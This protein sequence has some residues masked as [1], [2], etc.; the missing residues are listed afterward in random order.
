MLLRPS[1]PPAHLAT[2]PPHTRMPSAPPLQSLRSFLQQFLANEVWTLVGRRIY[3]D[4][5]LAKEGT[6]ELRPFLAPAAAA[7]GAVPPPSFAPICPSFVGTAASCSAGA[8]CR[9]SHAR[10]RLF[11]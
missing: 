8:S 2:P 4:P 3:T 11:A 7:P 6:A 9:L 1:P 10:A 5:A